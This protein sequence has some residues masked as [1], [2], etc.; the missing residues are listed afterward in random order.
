MAR[1]TAVYCSWYCW[2]LAHYEADPILAEVE[3]ATG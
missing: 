1:G 2:H 3:R